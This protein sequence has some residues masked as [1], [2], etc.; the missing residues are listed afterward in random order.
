MST[1]SQWSL[2]FLNDNLNGDDYVNL[3]CKMLREKFALHHEKCKLCAQGAI[4]NLFK[5]RTL[6]F[7]N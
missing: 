2:T 4:K 6:E 7:W 5:T 3:K 1:L